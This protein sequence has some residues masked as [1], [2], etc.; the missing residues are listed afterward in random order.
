MSLWDPVEPQPRDP[1]VK[2]LLRAAVVCNI[3]VACNRATAGFLISSPLI[4]RIHQP[5]D[6]AADPGLPTRHPGAVTRIA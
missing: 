6:P 5:W 2:A 3:P 1:D 4:C